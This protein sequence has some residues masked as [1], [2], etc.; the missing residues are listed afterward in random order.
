MSRTDDARTLDQLERDIGTAVDAM[1][2]T[3]RASSLA[4]EPD[5][6]PYTPVVARRACLAALYRADGRS[7]R[8]LM[9]EHGFD[10]GERV[11][12]DEPR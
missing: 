7:L 6:E 9:D 2:A 5:A 12:L 8:Q 4:P 10:A 3:E 11:Q 1:L